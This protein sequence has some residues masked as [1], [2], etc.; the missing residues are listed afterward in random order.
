MLN[1]IGKS[2]Y[3]LLPI[4]VASLFS[5]AQ[6]NA[7][8]KMA[9]PLIGATQWLNSTPLSIEKMHGKVVLVDFWTYS[10]GNC[11]NALPQVKAWN[12]KYR[13]QGLVVI[14]VHTPESPAEKN[15][16][17]VEQAIKRLGITYPVAMDN[18]Y[19]IWDAYK[20][21]YWPAQYLI[22]SQGHIRYQHEGDGAYQ[23]I[24]L[25]IQTLL[26]EAQ[27]SNNNNH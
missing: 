14:G 24:E 13:T 25:K 9:A 12:E 11:L 18:Q 26:K 1:A 8:E 22:D 4:I 6:V 15:Q 10:C 3:N 23:D 7:S 27:Q 20:N 5:S 21:K 2:L 19:A 16:Q 17:H